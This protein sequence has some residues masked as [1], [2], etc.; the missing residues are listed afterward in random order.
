VPAST[1]QTSADTPSTE[2]EP[3]SAHARAA[4]LLTTT[5]HPPVAAAERDAAPR[6]PKHLLR[7]DVVGRYLVLD[8]VGSGG[9]GIVY[10]AYDPEL[11]RKIA[12][13]L[14]RPGVRGRAEVARARL[15][16][17]A[18]ALARLS[19]P[20]VIAVHDVGTFED[21]VFVAMEFVDGVDMAQWLRKRRSWREVL[22]IMRQA[23]E[24]LAAAHAAGV[25]HRD[26]KP[27]N[28]LIARD[29][30]VRVLDFGLARTA[31]DPTIERS[32]DGEM[33]E[34]LVAIARSQASISTQVGERIAMPEGERAN[35]G[36]LAAGT[37]LTQAG[38]VMG[39]PAYMA[40]EQH[41]GGNIDARSDQF[42]YCVA[43]YEALYGERPFAGETA[44]EIA[45]HVVRGRVREPPRD[46]AP[47]PAWIRKVLVRGLAV[48]PTERW[49]DMQ[50]LLAALAADPAA[51]QRRLALATLGLGVLGA[52]GL[53]LSAFV[54]PDEEVCRGAERKLDGIW[55]ATVRG[56]IEGAFAKSER[57]YAA[58]AFASTAAQLDAYTARVVAI[59]TDACEATAIRKEQSQDLLDRRMTCIERRL[60]DVRALTR[61]LRQA[62]DEA[63]ARAAEAASA[64]PSLEPCNDLEALV[65]GGAP[66]PPEEA[67][68]VAE[69]EDML[70]A[71]RQQLRLA[72]YADSRA[73]ATGALAAARDSGHAPTIA[74]ALLLLGRAELQMGDAAEAERALFDAAWT[75]DAAGDDRVRAEAWKDLVWIA[76]RD[77]DRHDEAGRMAESAAHALER[78]GGDPLIEAE[79]HN[80]L[81][82]NARRRG[83]IATAITEHERALQLRREHLAADDPALGDSLLNLGIALT[84]A[85]RLDEADSALADA[86]EILRTRFG[87]AHPRFASALQSRGIV[88]HL[89]GDHG[90]AAEMLARATAIRERVLPRE[91]PDLAGSMHDLGVVLL[92]AG[93]H[94]EARDRLA[95][96]L[97]LRESTLPEG[98]ASIAN[99]LTDLGKAHLEL[100][101]I[102]PAAEV[103]ARA[104]AIREA[105]APDAPATSET[106]FAYARALW[107][108]A[109]ARALELARRARDAYAPG[110][111]DRKDVEAWLRDHDRR[112]R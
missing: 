100:G 89:R 84:D 48:V 52:G 14:L 74:Q 103:L 51:R 91:N 105:T 39:T 66:L 1:P 4:G 20:A 26:F 97:A 85:Q 37:K 92:A 62:D 101:E 54:R 76:G 6:P 57:P 28:V 11:D 55:D 79:L 87:E 13:K 7:G 36:P 67:G 53:V 58:D 71:G 98:H 38:A 50:A 34:D 2:H 42:S 68:R 78:A 81:G 56:E 43:L 49:S 59:H 44:P 19:H 9:M 94:A 60:K 64:L 111:A 30:R 47:V 72:D 12:L 23:G 15:L 104:L 17:E 22:P 27:E 35:V 109:P 10:A 82:V 45:Y 33:V 106:R 24:G 73:T 86:E 83:D 88:K 61:L 102:A 80:N 46:G 63:V 77:R 31:A 95:A 8:K 69:I 65:A 29:G 32:S 5:D 99:S 16:R 110:S 41:T 40:P 75:A 112:H 108:D 18:Q 70:A 96:A 90:S 93:R 3:A 21:Q 25:I 107:H